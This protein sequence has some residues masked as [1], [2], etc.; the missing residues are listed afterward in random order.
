M[1]LLHSFI[2][3][4]WI[5]SISMIINSSSHN[6]WGCGLWNFCLHWLPL[7]QSPQWWWWY[8]YHYVMPIDVIV[9]VLV[10][11]IVI[12]VRRI[13]TQYTFG[14]MAYISP[15][16]DIII[17]IGERAKRIVIVVDIVIRIGGR[18]IFKSI[19]SNQQFTSESI[20]C[21]QILAPFGQLLA[22]STSHCW[23]ALV[24]QDGQCD[25]CR[26]SCH[27]ATQYSSQVI[28]HCP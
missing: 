27:H 5:C 8:S 1:E 14:C 19:R 7:Y 18:V 21:S 17:M 10:I 6:Q 23:W 12:P 13:A 9:A 20:S 26:Y 25:I 24:W 22:Q 11:I 16:W 4:W 15:Y 2:H 28:C 3:S